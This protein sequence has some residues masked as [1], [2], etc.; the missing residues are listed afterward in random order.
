[1]GDTQIFPTRMDYP[2][3]GMLTYVNMATA[4]NLNAS[5][6]VNNVPGVPLS[7]AQP[8]YLYRARDGNSADTAGG[9]GWLT[10][11]GETSEQALLNSLFPPPGNFLEMYPGSDADMNTIRNFDHGISGN[12][13]GVLEEDEWVEGSTG[14]ITA[15]NT[16][17]RWYLE[18]DTP[19]II[20][21][22]QNYY[23]TGSNAAYQV[24]GFVRA[25]VLGY[26]F[27]TNDKWIIIEF[28]GWGDSCEPLT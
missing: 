27:G 10:W 14:N 16:E 3:P 24:A 11:T 8:G 12:G 6:F 22:Y 2:G 17:M 7:D 4:P 15:V 26:E 13:N 5:T 28:L 25:N 19:V 20:T 1:V 9:F 21:V 18:N 23:N